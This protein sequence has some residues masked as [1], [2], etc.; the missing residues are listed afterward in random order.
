MA[1]PTPPPPPLARQEVVSLSQ[2]FCLLPADELTRGG[3]GEA[4][5]EEPIIRWRESLV[6][7]KTCYSLDGS[8]LTVKIDKGW[9]GV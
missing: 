2:S 8:N 4:V 7:Y 1:P 6:L 5:G 3:G 9:D